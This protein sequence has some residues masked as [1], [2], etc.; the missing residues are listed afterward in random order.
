MLERQRG[1]QPRA[2][3]DINF[4]PAK[5]PKKSFFLFFWGLREHADIHFFFCFWSLPA[6]TAARRRAAAALAATA[7][8]TATAVAAQR[9]EVAAARLGH[10]RGLARHDEGPLGLVR[11]E[12]LAAALGVR[13]AAR[14]PPHARARVLLRGRQLAEHAVLAAVAAGLQA[15]AVDGQ[16]GLRRGLHAAHRGDDRLDLVDLG[17]VD[18]GR[19]AA[20]LCGFAGEAGGALLRGLARA[21][22]GLP[23]E[24]HVA[25]E[26]AHVLGAQHLAEEAVHQRVLAAI[27]RADM[28][29][30]RAVH[31]G[32]LVDDAPLAAVAAP[33]AVRVHRPA[34]VALAR[35]RMSIR[36]EDPERAPTG[37]RREC[38]CHLACLSCLKR[39]N[40]FESVCLVDLL[41]RVLAQWGFQMSIFSGN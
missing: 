35:A 39:G 9:R 1:I 12:E 27:P 10:L 11:V 21:L 17:L 41:Q 36:I 19:G 16:A 38:E 7:T 22:L 4:L 32:H 5:K 31:R 6:S 34:G 3:V 24:H 18:S 40:S 25:P 26:H 15:V 14:G 20:L 37:Q 33:E 28:G 29:V 8:A 23:V 13:R 2:A 30:V